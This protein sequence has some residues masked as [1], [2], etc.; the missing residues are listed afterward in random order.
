MR[1]PPGQ[2]PGFD[3]KMNKGE[4]NALPL[5]RHDGPVEVVSD[6]KELSRALAALEGERVLGFD[7]ETRPSFR[8]GE[9]HQVS[10]LQLAGEGKVFLF[11]LRPL[12]FPEALRALLSHPG[13]VKT[14]VS[15]KD[16]IK[17]LQALGRFEPGGVVDLG[18]KAREAGVQNLGLRGLAAVFLGIRIS[19]G[20]QVTNW[21]RATLSPA[22]IIYAATDAWVGREIYLKMRAMGLVA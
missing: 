1:S 22:Q 7:T 19:K 16:D 11:Q 5:Q 20:A 4:I 9:F 18:I 15:M 2:G 6:K 21:A 17:G 13:L 10:L 12:G 3:R 14:G 8:K